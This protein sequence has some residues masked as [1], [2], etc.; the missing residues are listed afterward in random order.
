G[1]SGTEVASAKR[2]RGERFLLATSARTA[3]DG[4]RLVPAFSSRGLLAMNRRCIVPIWLL[5]LPFV[6]VFSTRATAQA[7]VSP[8]KYIRENFTKQEQMIP[9]RDGVRLFTAIYMPKD[10]SKRYPILMMRTPY[11]V[12]PYGADKFRDAIAPSHDFE[13]EGYIF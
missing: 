10:T 1:Q 2:Q 5:G 8:A 11:S 3:H 7:Q 9:M 6:L 4:A 12:S 13:R